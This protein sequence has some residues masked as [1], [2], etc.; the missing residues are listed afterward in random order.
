PDGMTLYTKTHLWCI[1]GGHQ[2]EIRQLLCLH[3][4]RCTQGHYCRKDTIAVAV[5][6]PER[7]KRIRTGT[8]KNIDQ[9]LV[10]L[11][12][13]SAYITITHELTDGFV[14]YYDEKC[15]MKN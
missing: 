8:I 2:Y 4:A 13:F 5:A 11:P 12:L 7:I 10:A 14:G 9:Q 6:N 1:F 3:W 15:E